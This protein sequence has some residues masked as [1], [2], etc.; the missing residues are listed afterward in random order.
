MTARAFLCDCMLGGLARWL[1]AAGYDAAWR[2][3]AED[4]ELV[5][6]ARSEGRMLLTSDSR[7]VERRV[8]RDG[9]LPCLF[10]PRK[11]SPTEALGFVV[12]S[13]RLD[14]LP[15]RCMA[16]GGREIPIEKTH[17]KHL[18]GP[19]A[20][21]RHQR[22]WRCDQCA[23]ILWRGTHWR[24]IEQVLRTARATGARRDPEDIV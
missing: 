13:L 14:V 5:K 22:F 8:I 15:P 16:C 24:R 3:H 10:V 1:R 2:R 9:D 11:L 7:L 19:L 17:I 4:A 18:V 20:Y 6:R 21:A 23:R 12:R